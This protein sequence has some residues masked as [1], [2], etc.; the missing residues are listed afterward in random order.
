MGF[1]RRWKIR[2]ELIELR[3]E[4]IQ[5]H[6][7]KHLPPGAVRELI[8]RVRLYEGTGALIVLGQQHMRRL[9]DRRQIAA[10]KQCQHCPTGDARRWS[11]AKHH[12]PESFCAASTFARCVALRLAGSAADG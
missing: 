4:P 11:K 2:V 12:S 7:A 10:G 9:V 1:L 8:L 5:L 3:L 6:V